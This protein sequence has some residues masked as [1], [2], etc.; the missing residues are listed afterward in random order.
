[1]RERTSHDVSAPSGA[2]VAL[3]IS[4]REAR[5]V[6]FRCTS[7][8]RSHLYMYSMPRF[9]LRFRDLLPPTLLLCA[10]RIA[11]AQ[12]LPGLLIGDVVSRESGFPL[13]HAM[14]TVLGAQRQTFTS[15]AGIFA[16]REMEPGRYRLHVTRI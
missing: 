6:W 8:V 5:H 15:D 1:M 4:R 2:H 3:R 12:G 13:G 16:F 11:V 9:R 7:W 10:A 14:V